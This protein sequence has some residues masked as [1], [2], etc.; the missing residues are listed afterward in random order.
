MESS[1]VPKA[2]GSVNHRCP[3]CDGE[4]RDEVGR[5]INYIVHMGIATQ[6]HQ[7]KKEWANYIT[8]LNFPGF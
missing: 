8:R 2:G 7:M 1:L 6:K 4:I 3:F 5:N